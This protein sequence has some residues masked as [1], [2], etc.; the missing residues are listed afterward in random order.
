M[1]LQTTTEIYISNT[2]I[3]SY[4]SLRLVQEIDA[5]HDLELVCRTDVV[6]KLTEEL[7]GSS[8]E[9]LGG[10]ITVRVSSI[11][12]LGR[13][14]ELEFKGIVTKVK[15]TKSYQHAT[16][17]LVTL[18]AKS[19]SI[20]SDDGA[21]YASFNDAS[22]SDILNETFSEYDQQKLATAFAPKGSGSIHYSVQHNQSAFSYASR[23]ASYYN[24]WFYYDG[25]KLVFGS[26]SNEETEL[27]YG[28]DLQDFT[29]EL[30]AIPNSFDYITNDYVTDEIHNKSS[31]EVT[32]SSDGYHGFT[33][34]K[35]NE[36]FSKQ[37][38]VY[39]NLSHDASIKSRLDTQVEHY[40]KSRAMQAVLAKGSSDN[41]G[42]NLGEVIKIKGH[43]S[44]R[45]IKITH[46]NIEGG[47][48]KN[49]FEAVDAN[50]SAYPK[51][52]INNY[53]KSDIQIATVIENNDPEGLSRVKVQFPWQKTLGAT[54]PW[55]RMMTPHAGSDKGFHFI[56]EIE[57]EVVVNFEGANAERP[58]VLG[59]LYHGNAKPDSWQTDAND[60]KAIKTRSG[61][62]IELH[63]TKGS[64]KILISDKNSNLI[65][66]DTANNNIE[67]SAMENMTLN[68]K[69]MK[70]NV[71]ENFDISVG[72][73]KNESIGDKQT[74]TAKQST[75]LIDE[76]AQFQSK[77]L[78]KNAQKISINSTKENLELSSAKQVVSNSSEK[79]ILI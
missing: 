19:T 9:F 20:L 41:P 2:P 51:M 58:F 71:Q 78:E 35:S 31:S 33:H 77:E 1:A 6:E 53:P 14:K 32:I 64:E 36:I 39:H 60:I 65:S 52:D 25:K 17:H 76:K 57:E 11:S 55:L 54:T 50:F 45:V 40:T 22:L 70:I 72:E 10:I 61:H 56:P 5:H 4:K 7:I 49:N 69:N 30:S 66:I 38:Q 18:C 48:Y 28:I 63:D 74:L 21:H 47:A 34:K 12:Q 75:I 13:Y 8:K 73:N 46:T 29:V 37:T 67:I 27:S 43:G 16:G 59:A 62:L 44:F 42:V 15:S 26:P 23:L 79:N 3:N 68:A 24:E